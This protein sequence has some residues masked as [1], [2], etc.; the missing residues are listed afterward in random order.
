[1]PFEWFVALR[2]L[3]DATGQ[4]ALILAAV[5]V[6]VSVIVFLSALI[7]GLQASLIDKTLGS[8]PHVTL[9][10][11]REEPRAAGRAD[12][13]RARSRGTVE[14]ASAA[15]ALDRPVADG[16]RRASSAWPA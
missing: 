8:Q 2:Y 1:M 13:G 14:R 3:R 7:G 10:V 11:P 6:G 12:A 16:A 5:S 4:T 9:R 15:A